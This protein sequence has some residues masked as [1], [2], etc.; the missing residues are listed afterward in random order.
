MAGVLHAI[1]V[2]IVALTVLSAI[3]CAAVIPSALNTILVQHGLVIVLALGAA[4][5]VRLGRVRLAGWLFSAALWLLIAVSS[6][7]YGGVRGFSFSGMTVVVLVVGLVLGERAMVGFVVLSTLV[8][9]GLLRLEALGRLPVPL[10]LIPSVPALVTKTIYT[11]FAAVLL[12]LYT[13][14]LDR[15]LQRARQVEQSLLGEISERSQAEE[16]L[17]VRN[18]ELTVINRVGQALT[19]TLDLEQVLTTVLEEVRALLAVPACSVWLIDPGCGELVCQHP[20]GLASELVRDWRLQPGEGIAGWVALHG[21]SLVIADAQAD[22]RHFPGVEQVT[23]LGLRAILTVPLRVKGEVIGVIQV[24]DEALGRFE[25]EHVTLLEALAATAA[26]AIDNARLYERARQDSEVK[27]ALLEEVNH[28]V[29]NNLSA[30]IGLMYHERERRSRHRRSYLAVMDDLTSRVLS[31]ATV[32]DLLSASEWA[33][34]LLSELAAQVT[35]SALQAVPTRANVTADITPS[36]VRVT[37]DQAR[38]LAL[39]INEL[40]TNAAKYALGER[41]QARFVV[42][43]SRDGDAVL[44]D[45]RDDGPGYPDAVLQRGQYG[46]GLRLVESLVRNSLRGALALRN[47]D[48]AVVDIRFAAAAPSS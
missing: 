32:H 25:E 45:F 41:N 26:I 15:A 44:C 20:L 7:V 38:H 10:E 35:R 12:G 21:Q 4:L 30:I 43:I 11:A 40:A 2:G 13:R 17:R 46:V 33:P 19:A 48:G 27:S 5:L 36:P 34:L 31:L 22:A 28:R 47:E 6:L 3:V 23:G 8:G 18:Q 39:V 14:R 9:L 16:A 29:K 37:A 42:T 1:L 24:L